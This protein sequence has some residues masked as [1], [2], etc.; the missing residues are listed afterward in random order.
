VT[1][2][3]ESYSPSLWNN[4][5]NKIGTRASLNLVT[6]WQSPR[7][8]IARGLGHIG[9]MILQNSILASY[10][11]MERAG[12]FQIDEKSRIRRRGGSGFTLL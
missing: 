5:V 11:E 8:T 7:K 3:G 2:T 9:N 10:M 1:A 4:R 12:F 6:R